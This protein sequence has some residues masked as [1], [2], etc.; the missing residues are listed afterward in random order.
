VAGSPGPWDG[1]Q[2]YAG[3]KPGPV[4]IPKSNSTFTTIASLKV[5]GGTWVAFAKFEGRVPSGG[6]DVVCDLVAGSG[7]SESRERGWTRL[8]VY[9]N[10]ERGAGDVA[11]NVVHKF[12]EHGGKFLLRCRADSTIGTAHDIRIMAMRVGTLTKFSLGNGTSSS[13]G[14]AQ[15]EVVHGYRTSSVAMPASNTLTSVATIPLSA[16]QWWIR[17]DLSV[18]KTGDGGVSAPYGCKLQVGDQTDDVTG[19]MDL[20]SDSTM[21]DLN[22]AA[23]VTTPRPTLDDVRLSCKSLDAAEVRNIRITAV[24]L[25]TLTQVDLTDSSSTISGSG[26]PM[27]VHGQRFEAPGLTT[28]YANLGSVG[29]AAGSWMVSAKVS[30]YSGHTVQCRLR[31]GVD[32]D[33]SYEEFP[34][35]GRTMVMQLAS[36]SFSNFKLRLDCRNPLGV[37]Q[38]NPH[39][40]RVRYVKV[41]ALWLA[42]LTFRSI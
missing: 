12:G 14:S 33:T 22:I 36:T 35:F 8:G 34:E 30:S 39:R 4:A 16:G 20:A 32:T 2:V 29:L 15:P 23:S 27:A 37:D 5:P 19:A 31:D 40:A 17:A 9:V 7:A 21:V 41:T 38:Y 18:Y 24:K 42:T 26:M 6:I 3:W 10:D 28:S 1:P 25:G 11:L 13:T